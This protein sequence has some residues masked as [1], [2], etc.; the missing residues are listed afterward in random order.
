MSYILLLPSDVSLK[1][2]TAI[3]VWTNEGG[4][5]WRDM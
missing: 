4:W 1:Q 2:N 3:T 5:N